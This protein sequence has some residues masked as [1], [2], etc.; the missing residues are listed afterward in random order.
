MITMNP[1]GEALLMRR[2]RGQEE[3]TNPDTVSAKAAEIDKILGSATKQNSGS[4]DCRVY[5]LR[6]QLG[7]LDIFSN[8]LWHR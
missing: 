4:I 2:R 6:W 5:S 8:V 3:Q 1:L 7:D